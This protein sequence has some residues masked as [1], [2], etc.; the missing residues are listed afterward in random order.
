M[1]LKEPPI[2]ICLEAIV[3]ALTND[4]SLQY[5]PNQETVLIG[6]FTFLLN[7]LRD[8][9][10]QIDYKNLEFFDFGS[11]ALLILK[12]VNLV[13][14]NCSN[15]THINLKEYYINLNAIKIEVKKA[16]KQ[17]NIIFIKK[18]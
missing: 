8:N 14:K 4:K 2:E 1:K 5:K 18:N 12:N 15:E 11:I 9:I 13:C 6:L 17:T 7:C 10:F 16:L 3:A